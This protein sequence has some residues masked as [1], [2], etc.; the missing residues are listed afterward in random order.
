MAMTDDVPGRV[1][2]REVFEEL[3][4]SGQMDGFSKRSILARSP[5]M[6]LMGS[7]TS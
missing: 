3:V 4:V 1:S 6:A 2:G 7:L 5:S